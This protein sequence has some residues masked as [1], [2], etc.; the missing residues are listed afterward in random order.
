MKL[1]ANDRTLRE[2]L[3]AY[4]FFIPRFQRPYSWEIEQVEELW[5]DAI[6]ES[7]P[8]YFIGSMVVYPHGDDTMAVIDGQQRL[9]TLMMLLC[10][11]RDAAEANGDD[12]LANGT[13][14]FI[15]RTD[16]HDEERFAL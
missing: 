16:E 11:I 15:E 2:V 7:G 9:T 6:Q 10:A 1:D 8:D 13:H 4:F 14:R 12:K 3:N 5:E